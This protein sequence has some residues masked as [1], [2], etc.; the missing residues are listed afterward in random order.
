MQDIN[1]LCE[2]YL[3]HSYRYYINDAEIIRDCEYDQICRDIF[4]QIDDVPEQYKH[5]IDADAMAATTGFHIKL[6]E[7]PDFIV[8]RCR[9]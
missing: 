8:E 4:A 6:N 9:D 2:S 7:Y 3:E 5:I 1:S